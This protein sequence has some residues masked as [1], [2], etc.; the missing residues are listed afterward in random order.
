VTV[1]APIQQGD[2]EAFAA[3]AEE[4]DRFYGTK[5]FD[6]LDV[7]LRQIQDALFGDP[8]WAYAL[9]AWT[10]DQPVGFATYSFLWP[11]AGFTRSLFLKELYV[12]ETARRA[13]VGKAIMQSLAEIAVKTDCSRFE[14][15]TDTPNTKAQR[16]YADLGIAVDESKLFYRA[17][18]EALR[19]LASGG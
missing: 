19:A 9:I 10:D 3:L 17:Q 4:M 1:V 14:W 18:G 13:G 15:Q 6:P 2:L 12:I 5:E 7:R 11:A 8:P 16:F